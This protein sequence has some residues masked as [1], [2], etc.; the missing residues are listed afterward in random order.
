MSFHFRAQS[1]AGRLKL[2]RPAVLLQLTH[3]DND[4]ITR[5]YRQLHAQECR[6]GMRRLE[7]Q[8]LLPAAK[9][10]IKLF[11]YLQLSKAAIFQLS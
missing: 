1:A 6:Q 9:C 8:Q 5:H 3:V 4:L 2:Y 11:W 7:Y 10:I